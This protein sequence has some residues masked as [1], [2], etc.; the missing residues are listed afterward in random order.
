MGVRLWKCGRG[1]SGDW[2]SGSG[3]GRR[4]KC[5]FQGEGYDIRRKA[6]REIRSR[7]QMGHLPVSFRCMSPPIHC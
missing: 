4:V 7:G 5:M 6:I 2:D 1:G 3:E